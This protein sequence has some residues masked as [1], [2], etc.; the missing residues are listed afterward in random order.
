MDAICTCEER[1]WFVGVQPSPENMVIY[2]NG[3]P[4]HSPK[5]E[6]NEEKG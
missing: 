1:P 6:S 2:W 3:C 5:Q 4:V